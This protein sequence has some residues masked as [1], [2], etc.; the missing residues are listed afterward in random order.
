VAG[1]SVEILS[2]CSSHISHTS[3]SSIEVLHP[4]GRKPS[5]ERRISTTLNTIDD[6]LQ[7]KPLEEGILE[8]T[9]VS[10]TDDK[11]IVEEEQPKVVIGNVNLTESSSSGESVQ[12][13][14]EQNGKKKSEEQ[15]QPKSSPLESI[16]KTSSM[17]LSKTKKKETESNHP[18]RPLQYNYDDLS[19]VDHRL[20]L[21]CFQ[22]V[23]EDND[24]KIM[25]LCKSIIVEETLTN[26]PR[27]A[28]LLMS[29]RKIYILKIIGK[30]SDEI[31][32]WIQKSPSSNFIDHIEAIQ[33]LPFDCGLTFVMKN[34]P[35]FHV[36]V[37]DSILSRILKK[38][39]ATSSES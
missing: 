34:S 7:I 27:L 6:D 22:H 39:I 32:T 38:H 2:E 9:L 21:Y 17:L 19:I 1:S 18:S 37:R 20:K 26:S 33:E 3:Q 28:L 25:W 15:Q 36:L 11:K 23:L 10:S 24:E 8:N 5:E 16:F 13:A 29:T 12:T 35:D 4:F 31:S 30:E 14:Y